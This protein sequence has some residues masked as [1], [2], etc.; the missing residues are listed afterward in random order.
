MLFLNIIV[1]FLSPFAKGA[2][3]MN[4]NTLFDSYA[5]ALLDQSLNIDWANDT[6][7]IKLVDTTVYNP[8][9]FTDQFLSDLS[10]DP[11][12]GTDAV[13]TG[14]VVTGGILNANNVIFP[15]L[16]G[17]PV[18]AIVAYKDTGDASTSP[19]L[20][21]LTDIDNLPLNPRGVDT[22]LRWAGGGILQ[23]TVP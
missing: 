19:L 20:F 15:N 8:N 6:I 11:T 23:I 9:P 10:P 5:N 7:K 2:I 1:A 18:Q 16:T 14:G 4:M 12:V 21:V 22:I 3:I 13:L 17:N